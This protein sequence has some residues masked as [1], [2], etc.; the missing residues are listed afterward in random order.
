MKV[1]DIKNT[2]DLLYSIIKNEDNL[3]YLDNMLKGK[4][5]LE[6]IEVIEKH[7]KTTSLDF[8]CYIANNNNFCKK[9]N[10]LIYSIAK[11][12]FDSF[13]ELYIEEKEGLTCSTDKKNFIKEQ[14]VKAIETDTNKSLKYY[15][16]EGDF[17]SIADRECCGRLAY[18]CPVTL[19]DTDE[20]IKLFNAYKEVCKKLCNKDVLNFYLANTESEEL[21]KSE[22]I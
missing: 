19:E 15:Y 10:D 3:A 18:W 17:P 16:K 2:V 9:Y 8:T 5:L 1:K 20:V 13:I 4:T 6:Q 11:G 14:L 7:N 22:A 12:E 21:N